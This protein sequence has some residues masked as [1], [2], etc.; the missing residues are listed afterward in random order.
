MEGRSD[1]HH[2]EFNEKMMIFDSWEIIA[3][4]SSF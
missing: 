2:D 1:H 4:Y 3:N